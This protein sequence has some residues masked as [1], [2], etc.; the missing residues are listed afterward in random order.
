MSISRHIE[1]YLDEQGIVEKAEVVP[2]SACQV[3]EKDVVAGD[4]GL[5]AAEQLLKDLLG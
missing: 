3:F 1:E 4:E 2:E 5:R